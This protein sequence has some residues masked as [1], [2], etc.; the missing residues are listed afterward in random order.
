[1]LIIDLAWTA[2]TGLDPELKYLLANWPPMPGGPAP[3]VPRARG[4][5]RRPA[6]PPLMARIDARS[7]PMVASTADGS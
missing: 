6:Q 2:I 1:M 7:D 4:R 5:V 3:R